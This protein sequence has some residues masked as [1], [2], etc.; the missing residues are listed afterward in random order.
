MTNFHNEPKPIYEFG[1]EL[2]D[3]PLLNSAFLISLCIQNPEYGG[4]LETA[5][6]RVIKYCCTGEFVMRSSS[7]LTYQ[8][9]ET[10]ISTSRWQLSAT[11][12]CSDPHESTQ[13]HHTLFLY[14][15]FISLSSSL[16][17]SV[18]SL[19]LSYFKLHFLR[20]SFIFAEQNIR[21]NM[22]AKIF[23]HC[24]FK[25]YIVTVIACS[26]IETCTG[27]ALRFFRVPSC[28]DTHDGSCTVYFNMLFNL[29]WFT[30]ISAAMRSSRHGRQI[31]QDGLTLDR[32]A[33]C[34]EMWTC[35]HFVTE[36]EF[37]I[38]IYE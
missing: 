18:A 28:E 27:P 17:H 6:I 4:V 35:F 37:S 20:I 29:F 1:Y 12:P 31:G 22:R 32:I 11:G 2:W 9:M 14:D 8:E 33:Q 26:L 10:E 16:L 34:W 24:G 36:Y 13:H 5:L 21:S 23:S 30:A 19:F 25:L 3:H 15:K 38:P 7:Y